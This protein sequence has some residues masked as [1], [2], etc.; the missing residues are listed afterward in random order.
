V[1]REKD[2]QQ[3]YASLREAKRQQTGGGPG[4]AVAALVFGTYLIQVNLGDVAMK[5]DMRP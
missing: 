2:E 5:A 4:M 1:Q 3:K